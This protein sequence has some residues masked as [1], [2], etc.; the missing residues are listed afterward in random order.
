M[1]TA[2]LSIRRNQ[3]LTRASRSY[4][5]GPL[6][7]GFMLIALVILLSLLYL[8]QVT[9]TSTF[10]YRL[11][12]LQA[13]RDDLQAQKEKLQIEAARLQSLKDLRESSVAANMVP[14]QN[15]TYVNSVR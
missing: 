4:E 9:K 12:T 14:V 2:T 15:A 5:A 6:T 1:S 7:V 11:S 13:K 8:N 10:T 3:N